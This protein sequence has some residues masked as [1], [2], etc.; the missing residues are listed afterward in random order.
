MLPRPLGEGWGEGQQPTK[1]YSSMHRPLALSC[2]PQPGLRP[3]LFTL[4]R[5]A[6]RRPRV[7]SFNA[8]STRTRREPNQPLPL[9]SCA[10]TA[11]NNVALAR[12]PARGDLPHKR[13]G[14]PC[15]IVPNPM[16]SSRKWPSRSASTPSCIS[17]VP[18]SVGSATTRWA[19]D[20][21][22]DWQDCP[23]DWQDCPNALC[24]VRARLR[25]RVWAGGFT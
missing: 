2:R 1:Y 4:F 5:C 15:F 9:E 10:L 23:N 21:P 12:R 16:H 18:S 17:P 24:L 19:Q 8:T 20:C 22:N 25:M 7:R 6:Q 3:C 11:I 13:P 14:L